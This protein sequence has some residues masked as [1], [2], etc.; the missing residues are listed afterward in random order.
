MAGNVKKLLYWGDIIGPS[1][2]H[3]VSIFSLV[4]KPPRRAPASQI[5]PEKVLLG[6]TADMLSY[7]IEQIMQVKKSSKKY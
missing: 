7:V 5:L 4:I 1:G 2:Q 6:Q 3:S